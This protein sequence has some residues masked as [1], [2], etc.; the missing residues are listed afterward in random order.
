MGM[1]W[2]LALTRVDRQSRILNSS[3][4]AI[5]PYAIQTAVIVHPAESERKASVN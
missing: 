5:L 4:P 1:E 3:A 2:T